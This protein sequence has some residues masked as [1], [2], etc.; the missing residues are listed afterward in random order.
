MVAG[1]S[2]T[3]AT[4]TTSDDKIGVFKILIPISCFFISGKTGPKSRGILDL[5]FYYSRSTLSS[6]N[7]DGDEIIP[8][9]ETK[10]ADVPARGLSATSLTTETKQRTRRCFPPLKVLYLFWLK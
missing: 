3:I 8:Y 9:G 6:W 10:A 5:P 4:C 1:S 2:A 7:R